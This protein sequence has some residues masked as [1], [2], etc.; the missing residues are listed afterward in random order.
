MDESVAII[1]ID[2]SV[3]V[4]H[5]EPPERPNQIRDHEGNQDQPENL[6]IVNQNELSLHPISPGRGIEIAFHDSLNSA[7]V[8][9]GDHF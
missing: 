7:D 3:D 5:D 4:I 2:L 1:N 6:V 8:K 9:D